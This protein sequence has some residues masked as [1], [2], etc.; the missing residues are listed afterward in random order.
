MNINNKNVVLTGGSSGIGMELV[1]KI[2]NEK[3]NLAILSRRIEVIQSLASELSYSG[4]NVLAIKCDITRKDEVADA[5][6]E[7]KRKFGSIDIAILNSGVGNVLPAV[8]FNSSTAK[9]ILDVNV[10][11]IFYCFEALLPDFIKN[12]NGMIV[13]VSSLADSRG[14]AKSG[15]YCASKAAVSIFLESMRVELKNFNIK[16]ITVKPGFV[17]TP[18]T[19][20]NNFVMPFL[21]SADKAAKIII[22]GI[23]KEKHIIQFPFPTVLS[24]KLLKLL[25]DLIFDIIAGRT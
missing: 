15:V 11:G 20:Q 6:E 2:A 3:C 16:V 1:K 25:P 17:K 18:M 22:S 12:K 4:S 24:I 5:L 8:D 14:F 19:A 23:K 7:V 10:L 9:N 13:G 21:M